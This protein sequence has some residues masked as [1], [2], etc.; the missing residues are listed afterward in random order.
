M[1]ELLPLPALMVELS[2]RWRAR[3]ARGLVRDVFETD[4][5]DAVLQEL[6]RGHRRE[7]MHRAGDHAGPAGLVVRTDAGPVVAVEV[8]I[9]LNQVA[10]MRIVLKPTRIAV[11]GPA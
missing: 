8:L 5:F 7:K 10:P 11:D 1:A 2:R 3:S 9:E 4:G 6:L